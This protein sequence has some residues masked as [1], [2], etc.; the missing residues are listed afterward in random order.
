MLETGKPSHERYIGRLIAAAAAGVPPREHIDDFNPVNFFVVYNGYTHKGAVPGDVYAIFY[1]K[2]VT[3]V[4]RRPLHPRVPAPYPCAFTFHDKEVD[5][6]AVATGHVALTAKIEDNKHAFLEQMRR[7]LVLWQE[8]QM[9]PSLTSYRSRF[10]FS[11][12]VY[13]SVAEFQRL[14]KLLGIEFRCRFMLEGV[15]EWPAK[16]GVTTL[17]WA[18]I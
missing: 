5:A 3:P 11:R 14:L 10:L 16:F 9:D 4:P 2:A 17:R 7:F 6:G 12:S 15:E 18:R 8:G 1:T 13:G